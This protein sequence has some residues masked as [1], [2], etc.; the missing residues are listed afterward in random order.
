MSYETC[1]FAQRSRVMLL[2]TGVPFEL[3]EIDLKGKPD[4]FLEMSPTGKVPTL[5]V[6]TDDG[7]QVI[8]FESLVINEY[9]D[10]VTGAPP[11][12]PREPLEKAHLRA[13]IDFGTLLLQDCFALTAARD[14]KELTPIIERTRTKLDRLERELGDGPFFLGETMSL[15]DASY[16]PALQRLH[17]SNE[18]YPSM[19]LFGDAHPR[20]TRWWKAIEARPSVRGSAPE[21][22]R[23]RFH[24]MIGRDRGGYRSLIGALVP[25][26]A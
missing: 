7:R 4:W 22:V 19:E 17:F 12:L 11:R 5:E 23:D 26:A 16:V 14:E 24:A 13:W 20:V 9:L 8:L 15:V 6:T 3:Q 2:E 21:D 18:L 1:P 25:A 10:E